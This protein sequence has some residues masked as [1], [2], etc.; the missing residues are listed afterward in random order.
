MAPTLSLLKVP[1]AKQVKNRLHVDLKISGGRDQPADLR[2][3]R[4]LAEV[5]R[6]TGLGGSVQ[7]FD[8][9]NGVLDHVMMTDPEGNEFC[10]V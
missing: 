4:I 5:E 10:V 7:R 1:E 6:L 3:E 2:R 9:A 8:E